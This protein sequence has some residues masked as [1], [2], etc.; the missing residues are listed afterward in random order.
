MFDGKVESIKLFFSGLIAGG[1]SLIGTSFKYIIAL[2]ILMSVDTIFGWVK[3]KKLKKWKSGAARWGFIGK[4]IE[5]IFI[6]VLYIL[7]AAFETDF[8]KY[9]GIFYFG[10]C[11][12]ASI[13]ENYAEINGNLPDG[14]VEVAEKVQFSIGTVVMRKIKNIIDS[15]INNDKEE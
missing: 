11:E 13:V 4:I 7:D 2:I 9:V 15:F 6:V 1:A 3:A 12:L 10:A 5:L 14:A 8:L